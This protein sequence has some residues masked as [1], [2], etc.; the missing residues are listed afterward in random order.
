MFSDLRL[1]IRGLARTLGFTVVAALVLALG[2]GANTAIFN[3]VD[4]ALLKPMPY[5]D[6]SRLVRIS[7]LHPQA[8]VWFNR[9][10]VELLPEFQANRAFK[11][12][13]FYRAGGVNLGRGL[14][15]RRQA[16]VVTA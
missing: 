14:I 15:E 11:N 2:I 10:G 12:I 4:A 1:A 13:S 5:P 6:S 9:R 8:F 7:A 3:V 16:A